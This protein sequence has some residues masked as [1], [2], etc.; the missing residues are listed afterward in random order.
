MQACRQHNVTRQWMTPLYWRSG[1]RRI[2]ADSGKA[3]LPNR[4]GRSFIKKRRPEAPLKFGGETSCGRGLAVARL[5]HIGCRLVVSSLTVARV[6]D[7]NS[8]SGLISPWRAWTR[9]GELL[10][11]RPILGIVASFSS[12]RSQS[13]WIM[14]RR[15]VFASPRHYT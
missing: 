13:E 1:A 7:V 10:R 12:S 8:E 15:P 5:H 14:S 6:C 4:V 2:L 3:I 9:A 11:L